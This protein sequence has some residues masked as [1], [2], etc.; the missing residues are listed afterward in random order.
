MKKDKETLRA[1]RKQI[2]KECLELSKKGMRISEIVQAL[3]SKYFLSEST[4]WKDLKYDYCKD[5]TQTNNPSISAK[6]ILPLTKKL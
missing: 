1:R 3:A 5:G 4:I 2:T 6:R